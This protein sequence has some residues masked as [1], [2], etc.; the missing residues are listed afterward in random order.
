ML[1]LPQSLRLNLPNTLAGNRE[2]LPHL[3]ER[4][5]GV[6]PDPEAHAKHALLAGG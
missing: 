4:M 5:I 2:L 3:F 1:E 6:H